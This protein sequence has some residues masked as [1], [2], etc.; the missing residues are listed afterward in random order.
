MTAV[1]SKPELKKCN[2]CW[3]IINRPQANLYSGRTTVNQLIFGVCC[4][5]AEK[6]HAA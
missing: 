6:A 2:F 1:D 3:L 5:L 4:N